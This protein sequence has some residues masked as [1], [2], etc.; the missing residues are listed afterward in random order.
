MTKP[1]RSEPV[2]EGNKESNFRTVREV[3]SYFKISKSQVY[4]MVGE[5]TFPIPALNMGERLLRFRV[6]DIDAFE[7]DRR[8]YIKPK[9]KVPF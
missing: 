6:K 3:A 7:Q 4:K 9:R 8:N 5:G 1:K 2:E